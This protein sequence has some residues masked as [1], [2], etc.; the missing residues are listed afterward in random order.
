VPANILSIDKIERVTGW[1]PECSL[2]D[3]IARTWDWRRS[4]VAGKL[5]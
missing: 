4:Q 2:A 1:K 5:G 3:G